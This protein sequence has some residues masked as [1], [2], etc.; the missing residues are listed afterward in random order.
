MNKFYIT[1]PLYYVNASP[2]IGHAYTNVICD[3]L[4][5]FARL[6]NTDVFFL[7]GT[8]EH[9]EKIKKAAEREGVAIGK[10]VDS[11][12][13][14]FKDLWRKLNVS[15]DY[16]IRT[17]DSYHKDVVRRVINILYE[18]GD[19]YKAEYKGFYCVPCESFWTEAQIKESNG[20]PSCKRE[21][22]EIVEN[23]Y[24]FKLSKYEKWLKNHLKD[25]PDFIKP[26]VRYNEVMSFLEGNHLEDL[27]I[28]RPK[29]RVSWGIDFPLDDNFVVYVWFD[30]LL[31]YISAVGFGYDEIRFRKWWPAEIQFIGKDILRHHAIFWPIMLYALGIKPPQIIFAHGWWKVGE[32]KISKSRGNIVNPLQLIEKIGVDGLRYFLLREVPVGMDGN[33][34]WEAIIHRLNS[35]LANDLGNL[36]YRTLNMAE[37]YFEGNIQPYNRDI[38]S[39]LKEALECLYEKY[40]PFMRDVSFSSVLDIVWQFVNTMNKFIEYTKPWLLWK[41]KKEDE[42]RGF[43]FSLLEGIR[44]TAIYI[45]P[46]MPDTSKKIF[47]QLGVNDCVSLKDTVWQSKGFTIR[48]ETPLFPRIDAD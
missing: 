41:E 39:F 23:N 16:F 44:I 36:V 19:V 12:V 6:N 21:V 11:K 20:C 43:L 4:A 8:D 5:R 15:Y 2:H 18:K 27:C 13:E 28:S 14:I 29:K 46:F 26:T 48:K 24:F 47:D 42:L 38:P 17:T 25:N 1:T 37:K 30:A 7:T 35:D 22:E 45:Y 40:I 9:G 3:C 32:D 34:S 10:F 33:F 31:N